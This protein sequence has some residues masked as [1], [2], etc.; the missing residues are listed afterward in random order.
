VY[1][2]SQDVQRPCRAPHAAA[3]ACV[4]CTLIERV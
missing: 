1:G 3:R 2:S 4:P